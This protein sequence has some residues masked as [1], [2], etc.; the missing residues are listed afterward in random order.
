ME[1]PGSAA[2]P[3]AYPLP[4]NAQTAIGGQKPDDQ[5]PYPIARGGVLVILC[6]RSQEETGQVWCLPCLRHTLY[7]REGSACRRS[8]EGEERPIGVCPLF[9]WG[10]PRDNEGHKRM[11][12]EITEEISA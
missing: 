3:Q 1:P 12:E 2:S 8:E 5:R 7:T 6:G 11:S 9:L 4:Y 10:S